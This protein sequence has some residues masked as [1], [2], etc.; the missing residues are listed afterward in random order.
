[1]DD[2]LLTLT[3]KEISKKIRTGETSPLDLTNRCLERIHKLQHRTNSF[4]TVTEDLAI[5]QAKDAEYKVKNGVYLGPLHGIP[6][7]IKDIIYIKGIRCTAGSKILSNFVPDRDAKV[8][9]KLKDCGAIIVGTTNL[10][11]FAS[12][13]TNL[14]PHYGAV[15][16]PWDIRRIAGG[17]SGGSAVA[18]ACYLVFGSLGTDTS[19]SI[20]I[21][22]SLCGLVGVKPTY[23]RVS[24]EGVIPL[25]YSLDHVGPITRSSWDAAAML[26]CIAD[27][28]SGL[29]SGIDK[30]IKGIKIGIPKDFFKDM[31]DEDVERAFYGFLDNL[32]A[33][34]VSVSN[35]DIGSLEDFRGSWKPIRFK[36]AYDFH[37][38][39]LRS[40]P[41]EYGDD[42]RSMMEIGAKFSAGDHAKARKLKAMLSENVDNILKKVD[43]LALP[44][45]LTT[46]P[47][48][49]ENTV[50][51]RGRV[52]D[53][54]TA[55]TSLTVP[56][57]VTGHPAI[58]LPVGMSNE[59]LPIG[60]QIVGRKWEEGLALRVAYN[61]ETKVW[62]INRYP[63]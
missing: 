26:G 28:A 49:G 21:P 53:V 59:G 15:K 43:L 46:A 44:T 54:Y 57:N 52:V 7:A 42:V 1:M 24:N 32:Q 36:E 62:K 3:I 18:V 8:V 5:E 35:I 50:D 33:L 51:V 41:H 23:G 38:K 17:S 11:E 2:R 55:L 25:S 40:K 63:G 6:I 37:E 60:V 56:F 61:F 12:G 31:V 47:V 9:A 29:L 22:A 10:H 20:R 58:T 34:E 48:I 39:W 16:N 14:N 19:G 27:D 13:V 30:D 4:I 45:T